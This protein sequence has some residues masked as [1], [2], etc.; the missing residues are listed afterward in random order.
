MKRRSRSK[1]S[2]GAK[3]YQGTEEK[4]EQAEM[5]QMALFPTKV[6]WMPSTPSTRVT[7][8]IEAGSGS[9]AVE[10]P[11]QA[12]QQP[13][14]NLAPDAPLSAEEEKKLEHLKALQGMGME[15]S[16]SM[17]ELLKDLMRR[18]QATVANKSLTHGHLN[19]LTRLKTQV[20]AVGKKLTALDAEWQNFVQQTM[21]KMKHH[22]AMYQ[23]CRGDLLEQYNSKYEELRAMRQEIST[24]SQS[25]L[26]QHLE[27]PTVLEPAVIGEQMAEL[28][29]VIN[30]ENFQEQVDLTMEMEEDEVADPLK[31]APIK[32]KGSPKSFKGFR[33]SPSPTK[34]ANQTLKPKK[35]KE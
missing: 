30:V 5:D 31:A 7:K 23:Q 25:L 10:E 18:Q 6:P 32:T 35:D 3:N 4:G 33:S 8:K 1:S 17:E 12:L 28:E 11:G 2:K 24:A 22:V 15:L 16:S 29:S 27:V 20:L 13:V 34:V 19:R 26:D 21:Q 9:G 14:T